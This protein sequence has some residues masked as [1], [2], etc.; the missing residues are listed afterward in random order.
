M[1]GSKNRSR[2]FSLIEKRAAKSSDLYTRS[3]KAIAT[4]LGSILDR[5]KPMTDLTSEVRKESNSSKD[6]F[7]KEYECLRREVEWLLQDYRTLERNAVIA[8][9]ITWGWL[10]QK[11]TA[12]KW[13][14]FFPCVFAILSSIRAL[15]ITHTFGLFH[16][17]ISQL[18][19]SFSGQG[20]PSGWQHFTVGKT[21]STRV[22][23]A[24]WAFLILV[25]FAVALRECLT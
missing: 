3:P 11:T 25:S 5:G 2:S 8:V 22:G 19:D 10:F 21:A 14:W 16:R 4:L 1:V 15:G 6:F 9:G 23:A 7:L 20:Y 24:F 13:A 18:E 17:Y 12:P